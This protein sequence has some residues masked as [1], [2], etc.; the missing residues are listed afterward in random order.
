MTQAALDWG[1][2]PVQSTTGSP[3]WVRRGLLAVTGGLVLVGL[4]SVYSA[5]SF[6]AQKAGL[7]D[8]YFLVSQLARAAV[9]AVALLIATFIDYR[10][11]R[12]L[13]WPILAVV[14]AMLV[15]VV[16][17]W[18]LEIAPVRN[19]ARRWIALGPSFQPSEFAK[20]AVVIWV[21][22]L[23]ERKQDRLGSFREGLLPFLLVLAPVLGLILIEPH[24][25][26]TL[27]T[28]CLA[29]I[30]L[31]AA[32]ARFRHFAL[33]A[34]PLVPLLWLQIRSN[35]YQLRRVLAFLNPEADATGVGYQLEQARIAI[36]AGGAIGVGFGESTQK[37]Q[38]LPEPQ[39]DFIFPIIA[40][41][42]GFVGAAL[43]L[44]AFLFWTLLGLRIAASAPDLFGRLL[45]IGLTGIIAIAAFL[46][47]GITMGVLPTTGV[48]LPFISAGGTGIVVALGVT[49][50]L[51]NIASKRSA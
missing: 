10:V 34:A 42:W 31:F 1:L 19:G 30:V 38:Y 3:T 12:K 41:E 27:I 29:A 11:Y 33:L 13:A 16:L 46:H 48:S 24:L 43:L 6:A 40:E 15:L 14:V 28:A 49:G 8:S 26:A 17:P 36:G 7:P 50:I 4:L 2:A 23:A 9:G 20:V 25:S 21:A 35:S 18:T 37:L 39:N 5:S 44:G 22:A 47:M 45:G 32:G 51:L